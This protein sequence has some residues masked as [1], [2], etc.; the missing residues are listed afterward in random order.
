MTNESGL[1]FSQATPLLLFDSYSTQFRFL[2]TLNPRHDK[3]AESVGNV[4]NGK[5]TNPWMKH[6]RI[7]RSEMPIFGYKLHFLKL[8]YMG[9]EDDI[10]NF[11]IISWTGGCTFPCYE[12]F[13]LLDVKEDSVKF[14]YS[15]VQQKKLAL[16]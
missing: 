5:Q 3:P 1:G 14:K 15:F 16:D 9:T 2:S 13:L 7:L 10:L 11:L 4:K 6:A 12:S 8:S